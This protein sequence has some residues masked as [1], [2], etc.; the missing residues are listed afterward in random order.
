MIDERGIL[1]EEVRE[2]REAQRLLDSGLQSILDKI[3]SAA[4]DKWAGTGAGDKDAREFCFMYYQAVLKLEETLATMLNSAKM[5][6]ITL[7]GE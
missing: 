6:N 1:L 5:A 3:K 2:G 4:I 7:R